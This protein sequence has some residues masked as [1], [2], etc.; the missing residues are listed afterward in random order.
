MSL[1][2]LAQRQAE[3]RAKQPKHRGR[4]A[5]ASIPVPEETRQLMALI[6]LRDGESPARTAIKTA[7]SIETIK[8][9]DKIM[10][11]LKLKRGNEL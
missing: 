2:Q 4:K 5:K 7:L 11:S 1:Y 9:Y 6:L 8:H 3:T 10:Q